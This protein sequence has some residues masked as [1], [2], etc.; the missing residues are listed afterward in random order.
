MN[1]ANKLTMLRF[2]LA[3]LFIVLFYMDGHA[4]Q[5]A[6]FVV[7]VVASF[8]DF[9][10]GYIARKYNQ[11]TKF[12]KLTDPLADKILVFS[13]LI[14]FVEKGFIWGWLTII[15]L[16]RDLMMGI[17]R[18]VAASQNLVIAADF[19]G[20]VKT[21]LQMVSIVMIL[22]GNSFQ[23]KI[24]FDIGRALLLVAVVLTIASGINYLIRNRRVLKE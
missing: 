23:C 24:I 19:L 15:I 10:D 22:F 11:V 5:I 21:M 4:Y 8:T 9:L 14:L 7:F 20:K 2:V 13:A 6:A 17:F 16:S 18:A 3:L 1:T 12:G